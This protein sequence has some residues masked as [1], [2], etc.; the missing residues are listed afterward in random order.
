MDLESLLLSTLSNDNIIHD[1]YEFALQQQIDHQNLIGV[2]K[3]LLVDGYVQEEIISTTLWSLTSEGQDIVMNGSPEYQVF[4][5]VVNV[6][7]FQLIELQHELQD[8]CKIGLGPCLKNK[9]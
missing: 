9:W 8:I 6:G 1:S 4:S 2:L 5:K 7:S 3:S